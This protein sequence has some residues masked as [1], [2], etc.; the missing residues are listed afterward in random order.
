[1]GC[2]VQLE[3]FI[4]FP[5]KEVNPIRFHTLKPQVLQNNVKVLSKIHLNRRK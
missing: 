1:M 4:Y 2:F 5:K 3:Y